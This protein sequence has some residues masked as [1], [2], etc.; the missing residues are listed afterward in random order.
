MH[1][2]LYTMQSTERYEI[3][4]SCEHL[5]IAGTCGTPI[6]GEIVEHEGAIVHLCGCIMKI[7]TKLTDSEC[8]LHKWSNDKTERVH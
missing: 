5:T 1:S 2:Y 3:C 7:K 8:P 6:I 4:K